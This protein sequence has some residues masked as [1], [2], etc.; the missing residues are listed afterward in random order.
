MRRTG[1]LLTVSLVGC[2]LFGCGP[3]HVAS[4]PTT[5]DARRAL[6]SLADGLRRG[7][8]VAVARVSVAAPTEAALAARLAELAA[9]ADDIERAPTAALVVEAR[10]D[11]GAGDRASLVLETGGW[12][13]DGDILGLPVLSAPRDAARALRHALARRDL[14]GVARVLSRASRQALLDELSRVLDGLGDDDALAITIDDDRARLVAPNG[15]VIELVRE[16]G[17]WRIDD[18]R[19]E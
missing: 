18:V 14:E 11:I 17:E 4:S 6:E 19:A 13:V 15:T 9:M 7:D 2:G 12:R 5:P 16:A 10:A 8:A 1:T 3:T